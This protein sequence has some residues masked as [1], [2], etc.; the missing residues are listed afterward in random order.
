MSNRN[1]KNNKLIK[2]LITIISIIVIFALAIN[3]IYNVL[4][5]KEIEKYVTA[6]NDM[7]SSAQLAD[8][9]YI[10][11]INDWYDIVSNDETEDKDTKEFDINEYLQS[12]QVKIKIDQIRDYSINAKEIMENINNK[13]DD[14]TTL[15]YNVRILYEAYDNFI[16][17]SLTEKD[18]NKFYNLYNNKKDAFLNCYK[19]VY[20]LFE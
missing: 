20:S 5:N 6:S 15:D 11:I 17:M 18:Y 7:L 10:D 12:S 14:L 2:A 4:R 9:V 3:A 19:E 8:E 13:Y 16:N 1:D